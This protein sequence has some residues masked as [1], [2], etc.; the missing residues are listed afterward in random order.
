MTWSFGCILYFLYKKQNAFR[1]SRK[2]QIEII[3][4]KLVCGVGITNNQVI[5]LKE[6]YP[7]FIRQARRQLVLEDKQANLLLGRCLQIPTSGRVLLN[8]I[9]RHAYFKGVTNNVQR[10][11]TK[12]KSPNPVRGVALLILESMLDKNITDY[13][14][15]VDNTLN[16]FEKVYTEEEDIE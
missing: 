1:I 3:M 7:S 10:I 9:Q 6:L 16:L 13:Q 5:E 14:C 12:R 15:I 2:D 8:N 4:D 11:P